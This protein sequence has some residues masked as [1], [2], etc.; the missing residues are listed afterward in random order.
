MRSITNVMAHKGHRLPRTI[1]VIGFTIPTIGVI[2]LLVYS[3]L[4]KAEAYI[5]HYPEGKVC[6]LNFEKGY[7]WL[8]LGPVLVALLFNLLVTGLA[9]VAAFK[10]ATFR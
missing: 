9:V 7:M 3:Y 2:A 4:Y 1:Q 8:L 5:R 6:F 10:S